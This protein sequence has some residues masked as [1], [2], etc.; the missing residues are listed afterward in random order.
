MKTTGI[1]YHDNLIEVDLR[2][3]F[4]MLD[5]AMGT[6]IHRLY[7][8]VDLCDFVSLTHPDVISRTHLDYIEAG[9]DIISTNT[10]NANAVS[11]AHYRDLSLVR[12]INLAGACLACNAA[13][14]AL[15]DMGRHVYVAGSMGP[16]SVLLSMA[17]TKRYGDVAAMFDTVTEAYRCQAEALIEGGVDLLLLETIVDSRNAQAAIRGIRRAFDNAGRSA[18]FML[19]LSPNES[20]RLLSGETIE[21]FVTLV[22]DAGALSI[23]LNCGFGVGHLGSFLDK[24][25]PLHCHVSMHPNAGL[26]DEHGKYPQTPEMLA[27]AMAGY[28]RQGKL[29]IAGGCCGTTPEHIRAIA[30]I[31]KECEPRRTLGKQTR[32]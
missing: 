32:Y 31:A 7:P 3:G 4:L 20:G 9:A 22:Q 30:A 12:D 8:N 24:L 23:G 26:P 13:A 11:L 5:G 27:T 18:P 19:S 2:N 17:E 14:T 10:F 6:V 15:H 29:N 25:R 16:T 1:D 28:M 21:E